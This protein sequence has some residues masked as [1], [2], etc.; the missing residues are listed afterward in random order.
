M[1]ES[2]KTLSARS[3]FPVLKLLHR[4]K[5]FKKKF[6]KW[7]PAPN[8]RIPNMPSQW[9]PS[10]LGKPF[11]PIL[12]LIPQDRTQSYL[13]VFLLCYSSSIAY[14]SLGR[15]RAPLTSSTV[16]TLWWFMSFHPT[17]EAFNESYKWL[18]GTHLCWVTKRNMCST[19]RTESPFQ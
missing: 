1:K 13:F 18:R 7:H 5:C 17:T 12:E 9:R 8:N 16:S 3:W 6:T 4:N 19:E 14:P 2:L 15:R 10:L 11:L